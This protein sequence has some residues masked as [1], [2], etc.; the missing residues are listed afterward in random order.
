MKCP[1]CNIDMIVVEH[2]K[3]EL[4]YCT[5]CSGV[6]FDAGELEL[7][8]K[9]E[10]VKGTHFV[11]APPQ[12]ASSEGKRRCPICRKKMDKVLIGEEPKVLVDACPQ[13]DG[14]WFDGGEVD[15]LI[16]QQT[17]KPSGEAIVSFLSDVFQARDKT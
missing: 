15:Q 4:D 14:L 11:P 13:Q 1:V 9:D 16:N 10:R 7:L 17:G 6:W 12:I 8:L 3:I 2:K 5:R